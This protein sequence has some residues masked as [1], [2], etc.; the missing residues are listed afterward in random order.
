MEDYY[1][2]LTASRTFYKLNND[3]AG[4]VTL[5]GLQHLLTIIKYDC[6][7]DMKVYAITKMIE[8]LPCY[9]NDYKKRM[10]MLKKSL[11]LARA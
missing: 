6:S 10:E 9:S 7:K 1:F 11:T 3:V 2:T 8:G 4:N 5:S